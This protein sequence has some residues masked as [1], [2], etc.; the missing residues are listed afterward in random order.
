LNQAVVIDDTAFGYPRRKLSDIPDGEYWVQAVLHVYETF[1]RADGYTVKLPMDRG[2]GQQW[3]KAP[4]NLYSTP[5]RIRI[6]RQSKAMV[7]LALDKVMPPIEP[8]K[9]TKYIKHVRI[10]SQKLSEFWG[11]PMYLGAN[12]L[13]PEGFDQHPEARYP[14]VIFHG[15]FAADFDGFRETPPD[16]NLK[17]EYSA[18]FKLE[19]YNKIEQQYAHEFYKD[20]ISKDFPRVIIIEIQHA[21]PYYDDSYAVNSANLGPYGDAIT[22]ELIPRLRNSFAALDKAG[23]AFSTAARPAVGKRSPLKS[24]TLTNTTAAGRRVPTR[25][26]SAP[27]RSS[28]STSTRTPTMLKASGSARR[29]PPNATTSAS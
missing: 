12:V 4:G 11:R 29:A 2:E 22:Y 19:G 25:L 20:W 14:L 16:P 15:H 5:Q 18:R 8:A 26:I 3:N 10:K 24:S 7:R 23:R 6:E 17:P 9:D 21:N 28:I 27:T 1:K 13:L